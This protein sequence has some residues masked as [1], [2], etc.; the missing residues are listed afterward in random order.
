M[1]CLHVD[2]VLG[3]MWIGFYGYSVRFGDPQFWVTRRLG[4]ARPSSRARSPRPLHRASIDSLAC[5]VP[6]P[7]LFL[8]FLA[9]LG[10]GELPSRLSA[11]ESCILL[12]KITLSYICYKAP[13]QPT[14][15]P[16]VGSG[17]AVLPAPWAAPPLPLLD[18][19]KSHRKCY[20]KHIKASEL[21]FPS[22]TLN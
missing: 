11:S 19:C 22:A 8:A 6:S 5:M 13:N 3:N 15:H 18:Q 12:R 10:Q 21:V 9:S 4:S 1:L 14:Q 20:Q 7:P 2:M 16:P 17:Y